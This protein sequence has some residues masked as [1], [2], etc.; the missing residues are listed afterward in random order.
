MNKVALIG[1]ITKDLELRHTK[2]GK[3]VCDFTIATSR[4]GKKEADFINCEVWDSQAENLTE[5]QGK[6]SLIGVIGELR[7]ESNEVNGKKYNKVYILVNSI[8]YLSPLKKEAE[9]EKLNPYEEFGKQLDFETDDR[10][11]YPF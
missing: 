11:E 6:G 8:D 4:I 2:T 1:R 3:A 10:E 9:E 5:Y 7:T